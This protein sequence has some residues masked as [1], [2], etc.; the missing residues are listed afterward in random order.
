MIEH[1]RL[2]LHQRLEFLP[3]K[4]PGKPR[5]TSRHS[6]FGRVVSIVCGRCCPARIAP[7]RS[8]RSGLPMSATLPELNPQVNSAANAS[9]ASAQLLI[10]A[11]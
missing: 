11:M 2:L 1:A 10:V 5:V 3:K 9:S 4:K 6:T 8:I 7:A